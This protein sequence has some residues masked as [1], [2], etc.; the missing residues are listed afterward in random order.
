MTDR[1]WEFPTLAN[2]NALFP[3]DAGRHIDGVSVPRTSRRGANRMDAGPGRGW[4]SPVSY[5]H[6]RAHET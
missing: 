3:K 4:D 2:S 5:T 1:P 6:L